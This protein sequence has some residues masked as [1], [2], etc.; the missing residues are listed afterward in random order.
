MYNFVSGVNFWKKNLWE[1]FLGIVEKKRK[2]CEK[3]EVKVFC[4]I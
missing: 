2:N 4:V 1:L 3:L